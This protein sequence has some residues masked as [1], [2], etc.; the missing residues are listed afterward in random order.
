MASKPPLDGVRVVDLSSTF[1]GPYCTLLL[2]QWGA[3]VVKVEPPAGDVVRYIGD[4]RGTGMGPVFLNVNRG[5][6]GV[7]LDLKHAGAREVLERLVGGADVF[8]HNLRPAAARR[9][10]IT[11]EDVLG[12]NPRAVYC[13]LR[14][15]GAG[16]PYADRPAYDDVI[17]AASGMAAVQG[18]P[19]G[20][21][22][23]LRTAAA[24]KT[25]GLMAA[26]AVL[27]ALHGRQASG[28]GQVVEVP[29]LET[30]AGFMLLEQQGGWVFDPPAGP[31]GYARTESP[32]RRPYRTADGELA[33]MI[34]TDG[35]WRAFFEAIGRP[36][37]ADDPR[38]RTIRERTEHIDELYALVGAELATRS[39]AAWQAELDARDIP[40][41]RVNS[42]SDLFEDPH[43][44]ATGFFERVDHPVAGPLRLAR[45]AVSVGQAEVP[46]RPA[47]V[48]GEHTA[49]VLR[50][51]GLTG[52]DI[53]RLR[54][55][56]VL[57]ADRPVTGRPGPADT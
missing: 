43:L 9:L 12:I 52:A 26:A 14:G 23:Y 8:V 33:V 27:A 22:E 11:A 31:T 30:M 15:F 17:Q 2:A 48:L 5:K 40:A 18:G 39:T 34:Y 7:A 29:M 19:G 36:A 51:L 56:G 32:H 1:M 13:A 16:G 25:V 38:Y 6:R 35:Q 10:R 4:S 53:E 55:A 50:E 46:L 54:G 21:A 45:P 3:D 41:T 57:H 28:R 42:V 44:K 24:D 37:L 49:E 47:P 20:S